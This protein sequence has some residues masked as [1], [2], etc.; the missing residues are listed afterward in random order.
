MVGESKTSSTRTRSTRTS[1]IKTRLIGTRST[2]TQSTR[3]SLVPQ[4]QPQQAGE[5]DSVQPTELQ[6]GRMCSR[7]TDRLWFLSQGAHGPE[8][9]PLLMSGR[10]DMDEADGGRAGES[11]TTWFHQ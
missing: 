1:F 7:R 8:R 11:A 5:S 6:V 3:T 10:A 4:Q 9:R 2:R